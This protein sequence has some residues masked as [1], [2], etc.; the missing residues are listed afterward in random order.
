MCTKRSN[1]YEKKKDSDFIEDYLWT[2]CK[3]TCGLWPIQGD[4]GTWFYR[5]VIFGMVLICG[6]IDFD[7][8]GGRFLIQIWCFT[9]SPHPITF[10]YQDPRCPILTIYNIWKYL[11]CSKQNPGIHKPFC[12]GGSPVERNHIILRTGLEFPLGF[13]GGQPP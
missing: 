12:E 1:I 11:F 2:I 6:P 4:P 3:P 9:Q 7:F 10:F 8:I 5:D 13:Q